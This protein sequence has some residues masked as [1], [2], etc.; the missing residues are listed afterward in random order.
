MKEEKLSGWARVTFI[1]GAVLFSW[2]IIGLAI[3]GAFR[4]MEKFL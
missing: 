1:I 3:Y 4:I 2:T